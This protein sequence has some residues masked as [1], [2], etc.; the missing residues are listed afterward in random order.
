MQL[1]EL[2]RKVDSIRSQNPGK[3]VHFPDSVWE[4]IADLSDSISLRTLAQELGLNEQ[5]LSRQVRKRKRRTTP[6]ENNF[7]EVPQDLL[8]SDRKQISI[9]LPQGITVRIDL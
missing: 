9:N 7:L 1:K 8:R 3:R 4:K 6:E 5:N 2:R